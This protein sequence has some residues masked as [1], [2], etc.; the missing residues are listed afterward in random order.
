M[1]IAEGLPGTPHDGPDG[2]VARQLLQ[3]VPALRAF[4]IAL[5]RDT[6]VA[7]DLVQDTLLRAW[8]RFEMFRPGTCLKAWLF[9]ILRNLY[10]SDLRRQ[11]RR[12]QANVQMHLGD[13]VQKPAH[14]ATLAMGEFL[15]ALQDLPASQREALILVGASGFSVEEAAQMMGVAQGTVKSRVSRAR[16]RLCELLNLAPGDMPFGRDDG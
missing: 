7:D 16:A 4:A 9:T 1:N 10:Y 14:D 5:S 2:L 6:A 15:A 8:S 13:R 11:Q 12:G 3:E